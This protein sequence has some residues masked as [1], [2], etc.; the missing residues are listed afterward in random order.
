MKLQGIS[1]CLQ[2]REN[3]EG[4]YQRK[5]QQKNN[6]TEAAKS[7]MQSSAL[8]LSLVLRSFRCKIHLTLA[9]E[10]ELSPLGLEGECNCCSMRCRSGNGR[11]ITGTAT[12]G[13]NKLRLKKKRD[14]YILGAFEWHHPQE[15]VLWGKYY[16]YNQIDK[17]LTYLYSLWFYTGA[18]KIVRIGAL[19]IIEYL[20]NAR[21]RSKTW[22]PTTFIVFKCLFPRCC[23]LCLC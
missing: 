16:V 1:L 9:G 22:S 7:K 18:W 2:T 23:N 6:I 20:S 11:N 21:V 12:V 5:S 3:F 13:H 17:K 19:A 4:G 8:L 15:E 10:G 14:A